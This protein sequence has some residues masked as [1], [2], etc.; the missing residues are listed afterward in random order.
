MSH[1]ILNVISKN[2]KAHFKNTVLFQCSLP[3]DR[4][5]FQYFSSQYFLQ[6]LSPDAMSL[7][8]TPHIEHGQQVSPF[9]L[10]GYFKHSLNLEKQLQSLTLLLLT[11]SSNKLCALL[12]M[13]SAVDLSVTLASIPSSPHSATCQSPSSPILDHKLTR[14]LVPGL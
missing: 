11:T 5:H 10:T 2:E 12:R 8:S 7:L 9:A 3:R 14:G 13:K 6:I 4:E 1:L